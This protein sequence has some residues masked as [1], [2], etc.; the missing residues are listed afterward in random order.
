MPFAA[1]FFWGFAETT[2]FFIVANVLLTLLVVW[3]GFR[4]ALVAALAAQVWPAGIGALA[5][6]AATVPL[7]LA[8]Y[9]AVAVAGFDLVLRNRRRRPVRITILCG[10][11]TLFYVIF[12][13]TFPQ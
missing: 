3:R 11:G 8:R 1:A 4:V 12:R 7:R 6:I 13:S 5:F 2:L 10:A 9:L